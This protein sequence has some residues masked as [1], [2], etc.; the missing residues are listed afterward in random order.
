MNGKPNPHYL[1]N[2]KGYDRVAPFKGA[3]P[4]VLKTAQFQK[5]AYKMIFKKSL[6]K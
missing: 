1:I 2:M 5:N 6:T 3:Y 4:Q